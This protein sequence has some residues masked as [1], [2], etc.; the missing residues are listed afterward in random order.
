[1]AAPKLLA[2]GPPAPEREPNA[3]AAPLPGVRTEL[4][5]ALTGLDEEPPAGAL[6]GAELPAPK[7]G[8]L[9]GA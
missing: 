1:V 2:V 3:A 8:A 7:A 6:V 5:R 9:V 4:G